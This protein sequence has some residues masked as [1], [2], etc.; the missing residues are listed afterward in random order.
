MKF[1]KTKRGLELGAVITALVYCIIDL[2]VE[3]LNFVNL[4][5]TINYLQTIAPDDYYFYMQSTFISNIIGIILGIA[6]VVGEIIFAC[7]LLK[8][9][10]N[11]FNN[12]TYNEIN[13]QNELKK[14][15]RVRI[16]FIV[17]SSILAFIMLI[18]CFQTSEIANSS[19]TKVIGLLIFATI[20]VLESIAMSMKDFHQ[21][22]ETAKELA[23]SNSTIEAKI[24][25]LKHLRELGV[26]DEEQYKNAVEKNIKDLM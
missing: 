10:I 7:K 16:S 9:P 2:V 23:V 25:E 22:N 4:I 5:S 19:S 21:D 17:F 20:I 13:F 3:I 6:L 1:N 14:R 24:V 12:F 8:N 15:K 18:N 26:I 11:S